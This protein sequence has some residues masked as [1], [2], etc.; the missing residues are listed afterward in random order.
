LAF[1]PDGRSL[2]TGLQD[3]TILIWDMMPAARASA[4]PLSAAQL[5]RLWSDLAGADATQAYAA[6]G[7]LIARQAEALPLLRKRLQPVAALPTERVK[8][9]LADLDSDQFERREAAARQ[10]TELGELAEPALREALGKN[11]ALDLRRR[12]EQLLSS[13]DT[14][15]IRSPQMLRGIRAVCVLEQIGTSSAQEILENIATGAPSVRLTREAKSA[16][17]RLKA[18]ASAKHR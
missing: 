3:T 15:V 9:L 5:D 14:P 11:P 16:L 13:L 6:I 7:R 8:H 2:A 17:E 10:L 1:A 4:Q 12:I 18:C